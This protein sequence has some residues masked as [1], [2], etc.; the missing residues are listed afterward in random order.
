MERHGIMA[1]VQRLARFVRYNPPRN[2]MDTR[3]DP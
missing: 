2:D 1:W 3:R